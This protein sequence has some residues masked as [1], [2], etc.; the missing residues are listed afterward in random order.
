MRAANEARKSAALPGL[1][2]DNDDGQTR[3]TRG[4]NFLLLGGSRREAVGTIGIHAYRGTTPVRPGHQI[5][6]GNKYVFIWRRAG[7]HRQ[8][9][10][11]LSCSLAGGFGGESRLLGGLIVERRS[12]VLGGCRRFLRVDGVPHVTEKWPGG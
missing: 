1:A 5:A 6:A 10:A 12:G 2:F 11:W 3:L 8:H 4:K 7:F 9:L